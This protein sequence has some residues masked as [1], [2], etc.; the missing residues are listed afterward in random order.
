MVEKFYL[1]VGNA[2]TLVPTIFRWHGKREFKWNF[3]FLF[4]HDIEKQIWVLLFVFRFRP[5]LKNGFELR[6]FRF[7]FSQHFEKRLW[8]SVFVF[9][10]IFASLWKTDMTFA[11]RSSF[12]HYFESGFEFRFSFSHH[13]D[14][15]IWISFVIF[16][17]LEKQI[18]APG[19]SFEAPATPSGLTGACTFYV[20]E[21]KWIFPSPGPKWVVN[22][23]PP[24]PNDM[25][26]T[27]TVL[28]FLTMDDKWCDDS[29]EKTRSRNTCIS[30][31]EK[32]NDEH[33]NTLQLEVTKCEITK[34]NKSSFTVFWSFC[35]MTKCLSCRH[36]QDT[37]ND[38]SISY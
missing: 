26:Y 35:R 8:I 24:S 18:T 9:R 17:W 19:Q 21:S 16:A 23:A 13:F 20:T 32:K 25:S 31:M 3:H 4:S 5:T 29:R 30:S 15:Q 6:I 10:L 12:S 27:H 7:S 33:L 22:S 28:P 1:V 36:F 14:K 38:C 37:T 2:C 34:N 11:F